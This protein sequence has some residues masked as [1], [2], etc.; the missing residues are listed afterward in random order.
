MRKEV[1]ATAC[2]IGLHGGGKPRVVVNQQLGRCSLT[3]AYVIRSCNE[4]THHTSSHSCPPL[5]PKIKSAH[6]QPREVS[7]D[8]EDQLGHRLGP[9]PLL[10]CQVLYVTKPK[11]VDAHAQGWPVLSLK[12]AWVASQAWRWLLEDWPHSGTCFQSLLHR[13]DITSRLDIRVATPA[14]STTAVVECNCLLQHQ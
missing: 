2:A 13:S 12:H 11:P 4:F 7:T 9:Y 3:L 6:R 1:S 14:F 8:A 10:E 5:L